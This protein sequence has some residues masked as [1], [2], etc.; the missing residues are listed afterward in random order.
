[1]TKLIISIMG[2]VRDSVFEAYKEHMYD[3]DIESNHI[4][5]LIKMISFYY[6]NIR[7]YHQGECLNT[8]SNRIRSKFTKMILFSNQ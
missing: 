2:N 4:I 8:D 7:L 5:N 1:M 6:C 3:N